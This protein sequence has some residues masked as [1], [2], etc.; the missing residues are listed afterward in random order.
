MFFWKSSG[1]YESLQEEEG[2]ERM[3][4][5]GYTMKIIAIMGS[6]HK[7]NTLLR[8]TMPTGKRKAGLRK[9]EPTFTNTSRET[10]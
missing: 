5:R 9:T 3:N 7:G 1:H 6:P 2:D 8:R 4:D 10:P